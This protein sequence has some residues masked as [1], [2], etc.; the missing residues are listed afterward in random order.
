M[1]ELTR[2]KPQDIERLDKILRQNNIIKCSKENCMVIYDGT[3]ITGIASYERHGSI[4]ILENLKILTLDSGERLKDGL[5]RALLNMAD[6]QGV[7]IFII[8]KAE[9]FSFYEKMGFKSIAQRDFV[10]PAEL[11]EKIKGDDTH[12]YTMLPDF[13]EQGCKSC[14]GCKK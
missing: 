13:F 1:L 2:I 3:E 9:D 8:E 7:R 10:M 4:A 6:L 5:I 11:R 14:S 12:I